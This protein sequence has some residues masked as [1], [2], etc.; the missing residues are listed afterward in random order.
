M[1]EEKKTVRKKKEDIQINKIPSKQEIMEIMSKRGYTLAYESSDKITLV[2]AL[3]KGK[4]TAY[5][6]TVT[7]MA[8]R[9]AFVFNTTI[10]PGVVKMS[11]NFFSGVDDDILFSQIEQYVKDVL[12]KIY[13]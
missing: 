8:D 12:I 10:N 5:S 13:K 11:T 6:W 7:V 2:F 3:L 9:N 4:D 1:S